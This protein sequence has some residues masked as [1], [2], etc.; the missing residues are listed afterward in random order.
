MTAAPSLADFTGTWTNTVTLTGAAAPIPSTM[1]ATADP[2]GWTMSLE[3]RPPIK[4]SATIVGDSL[5]TQSEEYESVLRAGVRVTV[6]TA[7]VIKDGRMM[8][9]VTATYMTPTGTEVVPG[10][11]EGTRG[12]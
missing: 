1:T 9:S 5:V 8:G 6:R 3:G 4:V 12:Q 2:A 7:T 11:I 10:T